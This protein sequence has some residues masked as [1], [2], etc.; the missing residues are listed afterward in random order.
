MSVEF[1]GFKAKYFQ[2]KPYRNCLSYCATAVLR[3]II[4]TTCFQCNM[5]S[6]SKSHVVS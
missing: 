3:D 5:D 2:V 4:F 6:N 1:G